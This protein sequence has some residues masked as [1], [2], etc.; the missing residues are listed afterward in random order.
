[1][2][3]AIIVGGLVLAGVG[4]VVHDALKGKAYKVKPPQYR[5]QVESCVA[6]AR[7]RLAARGYNRK[8]KL[9][10]V[11]IVPGQ[12]V[13]KHQWCFWSDHTSQW[14]RGEYGRGQIR[15]ASDPANGRVEDRVFTHEAAHAVLERHGIS[16][17]DQHKIM[18][19]AGLY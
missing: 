5:A 1:M 15:V 11:I 12:H 16:T 9:V 4:A 3:E 6:T 7:E 10:S 17:D 19:E 14:V 8:P 13:E 18:R 2:I